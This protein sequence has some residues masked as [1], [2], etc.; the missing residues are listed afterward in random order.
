[1]STLTC[2]VQPRKVVTAGLPL[3]TTVDIRMKTKIWTNQFVDFEELLYSECRSKY[4][5][6]FDGNDDEFRV[7]RQER[8]ILTLSQWTQAYD[9]FVAVYIQNRIWLRI[10]PLY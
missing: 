4:S 8:R 2:P 5:L 9:L 3:G 1:M 7:V 6:R 10:C